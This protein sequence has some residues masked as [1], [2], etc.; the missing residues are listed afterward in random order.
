MNNQWV[1]N[2]NKPVREMKRLKLVSGLAKRIVHDNGLVG[3][4]ITGVQQG[5]KSSY[6]L[7]V[8]MELYNNNVDEVLK[9]VV[10]KL[11]DFIGLMR[12]ASQTHERMRCVMLDDA[13]LCAGAGQYSVNQKLVLYLSGIGDTL[14][15]ACKGLLL[16]SPSGNLIKAFRNYQFYHVQIHQGKHQYDRVAK[17]YKQHTKPSGQKWVSSEFIDMYDVRV[18]FYERYAAMRESISLSALD[19]MDTFLHT[20]ARKPEYMEKDGKRYMTVDVDE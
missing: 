17:G 12:K 7:K 16:T 5:G 9:H 6:G 3:A 4:S 19:N 18:P 2:Q 1:D 8:M 11:E 20:E 13:S 10:F 15:V 14:G